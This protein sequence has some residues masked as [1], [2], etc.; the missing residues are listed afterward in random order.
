M[1]DLIIIGASGFGREVAWLVERINQKASVWNLLGF[2][3]DNPELQGKKVNGYPVLG[4][5][6][7]LASYP[8]AFAVCAIGAAKIRRRIIEKVK[9]MSPSQKFAKLLDPSVEKSD[10]VVI[11]EG[12]IICAHNILTVNIKIGAHV[13][14]NLDCTIGHDAII[15]DFVT[16][17]PSA[18]ISGITHIGE[19]SELGTGMQIIQGKTV[20]RN[21]IIGAGAVVVKDIPENCVAVGSPAKPIK[22]NEQ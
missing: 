11:G 21:S 6:E 1:K 19:G 2:V 5:C 10:S 16:V 7:S 3:D 9:S 20:G 4:G 8:E 17:Y 22:A 13:I 15:E 18:N 12:S 14:V